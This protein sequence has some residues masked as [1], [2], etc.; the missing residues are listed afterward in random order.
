MQLRMILTMA[1][2]G[3]APTKDFDLADRKLYHAL[4]LLY[5]EYGMLL[6]DAEQAKQEKEQLIE[7]WAKEKEY[8][9]RFET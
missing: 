3:I 1:Y 5:A 7:L 4:R 6:V 9:R 2:K 8:L